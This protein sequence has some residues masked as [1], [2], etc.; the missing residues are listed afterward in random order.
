M[1]DG[2][3]TGNRVLSSGSEGMGIPMG[4][5]MWIPMGMGWVWGLKCHPHGS[6]GI[7][8]I[9][10]TNLNI[11][12]NI[13]LTLYISKILE[14][15]ILVAVVVVQQQWPMS[16]VNVFVPFSLYLIK[17]LGLTAILVCIRTCDQ[18]PLFTEFIGPTAMSECMY[19]LRFYSIFS[20]TFYSVFIVHCMYLSVRLFFLLFMYGPYRL[21]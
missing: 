9:T 18:N 11:F 12:Y 8:S 7:L 20:L 2:R 5:P 4:I 21:K 13:I 19:A 3:P 1:G 6:P 15:S 14:N 17:S 10:L 16:S